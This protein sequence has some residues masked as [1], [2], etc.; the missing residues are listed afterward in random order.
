[1][2]KTE[3]PNVQCKLDFFLANQSV[4]NI[5]TQSTLF[6][7]AGEFVGNHFPIPRL[8]TS[9]QKKREEKREQTIARLEEELDKGNL[10]ETENSHLEGEIKAQKH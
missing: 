6:F 8:G 1:M 7:Y 3:R 5:T 2:V 4:A 9:K 10:N